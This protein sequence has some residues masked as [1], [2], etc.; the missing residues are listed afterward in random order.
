MSTVHL[1]RVRVVRMSRGDSRNVDHPLSRG[2]QRFAARS[3]T[4]APYARSVERPWHWEG[5]VQ[6]SLARHLRDEDWLVTSMA[7]TE[8]KAPGIDLLATKVDR[9]L[10][11]R[12]GASGRAARVPDFKTYRALVERTQRSFGLLGFGVYF[13]QETGEA[14][15]AVPHRA[16]SGN[17]GM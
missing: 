13:I 10:A 5:H 4:D 12:E 2:S 1:G 11:C 6:E 17:D 16:V 8:S 7:D 3:T 15:L 9:W 14:E